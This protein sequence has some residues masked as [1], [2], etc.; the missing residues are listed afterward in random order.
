MS[1]KPAPSVSRIKKRGMT[2]IW[3]T[4][5]VAVPLGLILIALIYAVF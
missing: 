3:F 1:R 4:P 5:P 2:K